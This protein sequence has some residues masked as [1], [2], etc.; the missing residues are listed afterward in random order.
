MATETTVDSIT[1]RNERMNLVIVGHVDHG[2]ST[3]IGRLLADTGSLPEGKL[4]QVRAMCERNARPFEYAFLLDALKNEQAQGITIDTARCFFKTEKRHYIINDAPGHIEFLKNMITGAARAEAALLVIDAHEGI[5]ENSKRHGYM[6][7]MVGIKQISVLVNKMDLVGYSEEVFERIQKEYSEFLDPLGVRPISYIPVAAREG[8]NIASRADEMSWYT[9]P[10]VLEQIDDFTRP[11]T[12]LDQPFRMPVQ[13]I[14]KFTEQNDARRIVS[15][16]IETGRIRIG[17]DVV[18]QPSGKR[19]MIK[20]I[21]S[22]PNPPGE[23]ASAGQAAGFTLVTEIYIKPGELMCKVGDPPPLVGRR[24]RAN[25]F[26]MG[27]APLIQG[28]SYTFRIGATKVSAQLAEVIS[29]LDASELTSG[30]SKTQLDRHDIGEI[31]FETQR[32]VA[33]DLRNDIESTGRFVIVDDFEIAGAGVVLESVAEKDSILDRQIEQRE[34]SWEKGEVSV[35]EREKRFSHMGKFILFNG[36]NGSGKRPLAK[37]VEKLLFDRGC[38]TYYFGLA[39]QFEELDGERKFSALTHDEHV[40]RLG[41]LARILTDA[42]LIMITTITNIDD[43][44]LEKI[45]KL[46]HPN[47]VFVVNIGETGLSKMWVDVQF[48]FQPDIDQSVEKVVEVLT[49]QQVLLDYS[50]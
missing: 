47:E 35:A 44:D 33:F 18:F 25:V 45:R 5:Q 28:K 23:E 34:Y 17:D 37:K 30:K 3:V 14:Y 12:N 29:V 19:S 31:V 49:T 26:W 40:E 32:P 2:K 15:G 46:N 1:A 9:G 50:I 10:T 24:L 27:R 16:T 13:D 38:N 43:F 22:F 39:A 7:S 36:A 6:V 41:Q 8:V 42:G 21:E 4:D 20:S 11:S 48:D